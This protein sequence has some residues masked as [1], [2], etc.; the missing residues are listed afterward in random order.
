MFFDKHVPDWFYEPWPYLCFAIG[1]A[2]IVV[3]GSFLG[4]VCGVMLVVAGVLMWKMRRD[5][6]SQNR[7]PGSRGSRDI[8]SDSR[9][10]GN[11]AGSLVQMI[12]NSSLEVG[13]ETIDRQHRR[14]FFLS[15]QLI[16]AILS[17]KPKADIEL[18]VDEMM[19]EVERHF[20]TEE[21]IMAE[22]QTPLSDE[23]KG[24]HADLLARARELREKFEHG[25]LPPGELIGFIAYDVVSQ[26]IA[27][28]DTK[29]A[30]SLARQ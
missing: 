28:G 7:R 22:I 17:E 29:L 23:H 5:Y 10:P 26:H 16:D 18:L 30:S 2:T 3:L 12:W 20:R 24:S 9:F 4:T 19:T 25:R 13:H 1:L 6:R 27:K 15:N 21:K 11:E 8:S 14:L